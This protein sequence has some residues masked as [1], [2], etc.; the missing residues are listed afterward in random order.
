MFINIKIRAQVSTFWEVNVLTI[1]VP[2]S[3]TIYL[4][5]IVDS[6]SITKAIYMC[7]KDTLKHYCIYINVLFTIDQS[8]IV[9]NIII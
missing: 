4:Q 8:F 7:S 2:F 6:T 5:C 1:L 9:L 3:E